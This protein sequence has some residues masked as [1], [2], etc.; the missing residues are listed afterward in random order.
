M[1]RITKNKYSIKGRKNEKIE[2]V[3]SMLKQGISA[4]MVAEISKLS[5]KE[6]EE[7]SKNL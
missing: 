7:I 3:K 4:K 6:I 5:S 2:M 1:V